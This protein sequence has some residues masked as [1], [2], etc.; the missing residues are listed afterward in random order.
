MT[1]DV[2]Q[3]PACRRSRRS[4]KW[5]VVARSANG[6]T[7]SVESVEMQTGNLKLANNPFYRQFNGNIPLTAAARVLSEM[8]GSVW[9]RDMREALSLNAAISDSSATSV[10]DVSVRKTQVPLLQR[11]ARRPRRTD[12][13]GRRTRHERT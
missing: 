11:Q 8:S 3:R 9:L 10:P 2:S 4:G 6:S 7:S 12:D 13:C 5:V 1:L